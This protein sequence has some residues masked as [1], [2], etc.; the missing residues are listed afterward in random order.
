MLETGT[1]SQ[2]PISRLIYELSK[3]PGIGEK[4]AARLA[5]FV[6]K[7]DASYAKALSEALL[8][9]KEKIQLCRECLNL[10]DGSC[11]KICAQ[12][13]RDRAQICVVERPTD[14]SP[15]DE[16]GIYRGVYHVLHGTLSPLDGIGPDELKIRELIARVQQPAS[17]IR[18]VILALNP[19]VEG[20]ATS[21]Y[22]SRQIKKLGIRVTRLAHGLPVGGM[23]EYADRQTIGEAL[24]HR[25]EMN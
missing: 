11:C 22:L 7:Q 3:L 19:S 5:H 12:P 17:P 6:I 15:I 16:T 8:R 13:A 25:V 1:S 4:T 20:E 2:D 10:T 14:I 21:S 24:T 23:L 9:V 18:E